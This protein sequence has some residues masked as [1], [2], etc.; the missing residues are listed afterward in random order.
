[1]AIAFEDFDLSEIFGKPHITE[2]EL[3]YYPWLGFELASED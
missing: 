2:T 3:E 1:M